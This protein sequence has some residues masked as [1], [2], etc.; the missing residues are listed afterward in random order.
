MTREELREKLAEQAHKSWA[1][2]TRW[3]IDKV[4]EQVSGPGFFNPDCLFC[5]MKDKG[6]RGVCGRWERQIATAYDALSEQEKDSDRKEAD[7]YLAIINP[8]LG[9]MDQ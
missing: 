1:G 5:G 7:E 8:L 9:D 3:M 6:L 4:T 2:W